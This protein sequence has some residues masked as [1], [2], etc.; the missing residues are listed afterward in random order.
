MSYL[1]GQAVTISC[2]II[3]SVVLFAILPF[4]VGFVANFDSI[5]LLELKSETERAVVFSSMLYRVSHLE[6]IISFLSR[7]LEPFPEHEADRVGV[8][9][10]SMSLVRLQEES[11]EDRQEPGK[12][13]LI[14]AK[15]D[16]F[17]A[18][19]AGL[20]EVLIS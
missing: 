1:H 10:R 4:S 9:T 16:I 12:E 7:V 15:L 3:L 20:R 8:V 14:R 19:V 2:I 18:A 6:D 11:A 17:V 5:K 13:C